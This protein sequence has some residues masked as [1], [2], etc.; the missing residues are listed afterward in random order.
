MEYLNTLILLIG[1]IVVIIILKRKNNKEDNQSLL[2]L[3]QQIGDLTNQLHGKIDES[4]RHS[5]KM[6][7]DQFKETSRISK[8]MIEKFKKKKKGN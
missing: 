6:L 8:E 4:S 1:L 7:Q 3:Q 2:L 5:D